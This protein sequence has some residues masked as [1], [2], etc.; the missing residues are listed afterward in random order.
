LTALVSGGRH[1]SQLVAKTTAKRASGTMERLVGEVQKLPSE[2]WPVIRSHWSRSQSF[3][4]MASY[5]ES[6]PSNAE[7]V[8]AMR[9]PA[10]TPF[11]VISAATATPAE[12]SERDSW[13]EENPAGRHIRVAEGGHWLQLDRPEL[14][15]AAVKELVE[16]ARNKPAATG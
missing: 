1:L 16:K 14:V 4:A 8:L 15:V 9:L 6:L 13:T 11:I 2:V 12:L 3:L 5:L 10:R 7:A